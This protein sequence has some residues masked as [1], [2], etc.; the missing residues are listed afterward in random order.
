MGRFNKLIE[1]RQAVY[2]HGLTRGKDAQFELVDALL[3]SP[4]IRSCPELSLSPVFR[5]QWPSVYS[6]IEDGG[7]DVAWIESC[8]VQQIPITGVH[9]YPL[10]GTAWAH[11]EAK[12]MSDRHAAQRL[13]SNNGGRRWVYCGG[14]SVLS[15][16]LG[17]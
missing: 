7:Q 10:D 3:L 14:P 12:E 13:Q 11:P 1:F 15:T 8:F 17:T 6:A 5:R 2:D 16:G 9:I 4:P